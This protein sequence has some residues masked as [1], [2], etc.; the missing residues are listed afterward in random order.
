MWEWHTKLTTRL[1]SE[2]HKI[3]AVESRRRPTGGRP[4]S[5]YL[6][7]VKPERLSLLTI[8]EVMSLHGSGGV[9]KGMKTTR[10]L[11]T[12]GRA[13]E[14]EYKAQMCRT[15]NISLPS[16]KHAAQP[17]YFS[18]LGYSSLLERRLT[19]ARLV[20]DNEAWT[21]KWTQ[22]TRSQIGGLLIDALMD[23]AKVVRTGTDINGETMYV[24]PFPL[25]V[26]PSNM[27][28]FRTEEQPAFYHGYEYTHGHK[29]GTIRLND[30]IANA[31]E[32]DSLHGTIH[33]RHLPM[34]VPPRPWVAP[35]SGGYYYNR[36]E[37]FHLTYSRL[38]KTQSFQLKLCGTKIVLNRLVTCAMPP[39]WET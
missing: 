38:A 24:H 30:E 35:E 13:V 15:H 21:A 18:N 5:Q 28:G 6:F 4:L 7:L 9:A 2:I 20:T 14:M 23:V 8:M 27:F 39:R 16:L 3:Q 26:S 37:S 25:W 34:L 36:S 19:A 33:P 31:M 11:L 12:V 32:K 1:E 17:G 22:V 10:L 29:L